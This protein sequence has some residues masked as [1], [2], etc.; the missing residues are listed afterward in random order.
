MGVDKWGLKYLVVQFYPINF[1]GTEAHLFCR[2]LYVLYIFWAFAILRNEMGVFLCFV[3]LR[4]IPTSLG[5]LCRINDLSEI[6]VS[7]R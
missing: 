2:G 6:V 4:F 1:C 7:K 5:K 3:L